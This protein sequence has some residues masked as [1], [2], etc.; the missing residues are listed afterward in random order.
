M[1][2]LVDEICRR[3]SHSIALIGINELQTMRLPESAPTS[4]GPWVHMI[5]RGGNWGDKGTIL[6]A[7]V[8][9]GSVGL[10]AA[11]NG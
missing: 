3:P 4:I 10:F 11:H 1:V 8:D 9:E 6:M 5:S 7:G 2:R